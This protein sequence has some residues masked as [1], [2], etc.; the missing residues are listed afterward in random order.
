ML[1][2]PLLFEMRPFW[3]LFN[4]IVQHDM[5]GV[6]SMKILLLAAIYRWRQSVNSCSVSREHVLHLT[7][8]ALDQWA[9]CASDVYLA[10]LMENRRV[11]FNCKR[12][13]PYTTWSSK[14]GVMSLSFQF[15]FLSLVD[16]W[17]WP[18]D[19]LSREDSQ[20]QEQ[21]YHHDLKPWLF[22]SSGWAQ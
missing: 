1:W 11:E 9:K 7:G 4:Q 12:L 3:C 17:W 14:Y 6:C 8:L 5:F 18:S 2:P 21:H 22:I 16:A 13:E 10:N 20:L 19:R 15:W